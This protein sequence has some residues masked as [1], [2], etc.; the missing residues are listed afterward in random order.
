MLK[1]IVNPNAGGEK[2]FSTWKICERRLQKLGVSYKV[3][4]TD[5]PGDATRLARRATADD[6]EVTVVPVGGDGT[7]NEVLN[8]LN[9]SDKVTI[10][11]IPTGSGNDLARGLKLSGDVERA[12]DVIL[13]R[14]NIIRLDY[15]VL[16]FGGAEK[17][18]RRFAVSMGIGYDAAVCVAIDHSS[19]R[20]KL[21]R[22]NMQ[23]SVY[24]TLGALQIFKS[25]PSDGCIVVD[26]KEKIDLKDI[27]FISSQIH[28]TEGGGKVFT[29]D[30]DPQ[31]GLLS[32]CVMCGKNKLGFTKTLFS[33][34]DGKHAGD[35]NVRLFDC[36]SIKIHLNDAL[37]V[38][39]DGETFESINDVEVRCVAGTLNMI[40]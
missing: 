36:E 35:K 40:V 19:L 12:L 8:G 14:K 39:T 20:R 38:H 3:Y 26:D 18:Q 5:G 28:V 6:E 27:M 33:G 22:F 1:F 4:I 9:I 16:A 15:G 29:P 34:L 2:G 25:R 24:L 10:G 17:T 7:F 23:K 30:A 11:Y 31:D 21:S 13:E 32:V 37:P